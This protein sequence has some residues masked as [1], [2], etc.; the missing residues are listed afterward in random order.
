MGKII[1]YSPISEN[2]TKEDQYNES[3]FMMKVVSF[4]ENTALLKEFL[5]NKPH[6]L[7]EKDDPEG[8][9]KG[10]VLIQIFEKF[11]YVPGDGFVGYRLKIE[12]LN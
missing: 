11:E 1:Q 8:L 3:M 12:W 4:S 2:D 10:H 7:K 5:D 9:L 6:W